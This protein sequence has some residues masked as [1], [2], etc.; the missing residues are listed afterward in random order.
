MSSPNR[1]AANRANAQL[2]TGPKTAEGKQKSSQNA[3]RH[4]LTGQLVIVVLPNE[5]PDV[6]QA[7]LQSFVN[8]YH[9][10]GASETNLVQILIDTSWRLH[11][12]AS[13]EASLLNNSDDSHHDQCKGLANLSMH[14]QRLCRQYQK[15]LTQLRELQQ[16]RKAQEQ[17]D[18]DQLYDITEMYK[19][20]GYT[21][22][23]AEDGFVFS[24]A[25]ITAN[26]HA[27]N[28]QRLGIRALQHRYANIS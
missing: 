16:T 2:S 11:R 4:G 3:I 9:P 15:A 27:R 21:Y 6:Y 26:I 10:S 17:I 23:G 8:E 12:A 19:A 7:H 24:K 20:D 28:R 14:T 1:I 18:L 22:D 25:Q 5:D 13:I